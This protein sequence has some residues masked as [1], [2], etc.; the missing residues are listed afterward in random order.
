MVR[1]IDANVSVMAVNPP[2]RKVD[3]LSL[4]IGDMVEV[5]YCMNIAYKLGQKMNLNLCA[6]MAGFAET[7]HI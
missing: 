6:N 2:L 7:V 5:S 1:S 4:A 3:H